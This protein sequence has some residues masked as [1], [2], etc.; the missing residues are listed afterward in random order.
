MAVYDTG[1]GSSLTYAADS[2]HVHV[3]AT[4]SVLNSPQQLTL[5][6]PILQQRGF[7]Y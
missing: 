5:I 2:A 1:G 7:D 4:Q 6:P 3:T